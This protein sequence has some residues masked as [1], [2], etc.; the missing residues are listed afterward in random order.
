MLRLILV[1]LELFPDYFVRR[2]PGNILVNTAKH[3]QFCV[4]L[5]LLH[6]YRW[7]RFRKPFNDIRYNQQL[8]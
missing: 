5:T 8:S 2:Q 4:R 7:V 6:V 3:L 1:K